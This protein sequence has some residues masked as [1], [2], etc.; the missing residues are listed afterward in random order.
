MRRVCIPGGTIVVVNHFTSS[1]PVMRLLEKRLARV[2]RHIGFHP[3]FE[4]RVS[5]LFR[6]SN[7]EFLLSYD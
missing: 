2:A 7:F 3:D 4:F 5:D 6:I 1:N